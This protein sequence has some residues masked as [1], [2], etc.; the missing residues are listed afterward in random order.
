MVKEEGDK[1]YIVVRQEPNNV[2]LFDAQGNEILTNKYMGVNTVE[3]KFYDFG[4]GKVY[5]L[6]SDPTQELTYIYDGSG[7]LL[8]YPPLESQGVALEMSNNDKVMVYLTYQK[9]L[10]VSQ[11]D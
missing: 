6:I 1:A 7:N 11:L 4:A 10:S 3:V 9:S 2:T 8:T 5:Y